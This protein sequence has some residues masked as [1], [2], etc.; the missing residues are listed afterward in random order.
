MAAG[1]AVMEEMRPG[2]YEKMDRKGIRMRE[3]FNAIL[4]EAGVRAFVGGLGSLFPII[5]TSDMVRDYRS[6]A[7]GDRVISRY[8][9]LDLMN[10]GIFLLGHPNISAVTTNEDVDFTLEAMRESVEVLKPIIE[11]RH[12]EL[13]E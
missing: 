13:L 5:W 6:A 7:T 12:P 3:G 4:K 8:F 2:V 11:E 9:S 1:L 10:R